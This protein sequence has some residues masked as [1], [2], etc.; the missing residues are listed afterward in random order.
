M[1]AGGKPAQWKPA[2]K[3]Q[4]FNHPPPRMRLLCVRDECAPK[5]WPEHLQ[6]RPHR[7]WPAISIVR[8][9]MCALSDSLQAGSLVAQCVIASFQC[10]ETRL[11]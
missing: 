9:P 6:A 5:W 7:S 2:C 11:L 10:N 1:A 4:S 3:F 8:V